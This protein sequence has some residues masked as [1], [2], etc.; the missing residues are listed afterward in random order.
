MPDSLRNVLMILTPVILM[1]LIS[2]ISVL[3]DI[4][5]SSIPRIILIPVFWT[6]AL[7]PCRAGAP[8]GSFHRCFPF[9][10]IAYTKFPRRATFRFFRKNSSVAAVHRP[11]AAKMHR[12]QT[13]NASGPFPV[14]RRFPF[15]ASLFVSFSATARYRKVTTCP[16]VQVSLGA[17]VV[18]VVPFVTPASTAQA[19]ALA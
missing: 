18:L 12:L 1:I 14:R 4:N 15:Y 8:T 17:N 11:P 6:P 19:T 16:R 3:L 7:F 2:V 10:S 9:F 5:I 13:K